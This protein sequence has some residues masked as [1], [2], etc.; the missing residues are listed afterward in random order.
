LEDKKIQSWFLAFLQAFLYNFWQANHSLSVPLS[1]V[2]GK[3][4][5][6]LALFRLLSFSGETVSSNPCMQKLLHRDKIRPSEEKEQRRF[7]RILSMKV[8]H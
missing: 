5:R 4:I 1:K 3:G 7:I 8:Y 6:I 2:G